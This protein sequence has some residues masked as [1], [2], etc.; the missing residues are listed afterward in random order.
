LQAE[1]GVAFTAFGG[2]EALVGFTPAGIL[3]TR[4]FGMYHYYDPK[5]QTRL[6]PPLSAKHFQLR[7]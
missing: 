5:T 7:Q 3:I 4:Q 6:K 2:D 1:K